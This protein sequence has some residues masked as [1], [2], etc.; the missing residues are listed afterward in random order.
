LDSKLE[1]KKYEIKFLKIFFIK[2]KKG[3]STY[4]FLAHLNPADINEGDL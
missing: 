3:E 2:F 4:A 1:I